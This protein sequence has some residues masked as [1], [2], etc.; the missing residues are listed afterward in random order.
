[1]NSDG[2]VVGMVGRR[3]SSEWNHATSARSSGSSMK[4]FTAYGPLFPIFRGQEHS[5]SIRYKSLC[6]QLTLRWKTMVV[7]YMEYLTHSK[8]CVS[9]NTP[10]AHWW[11]NHLVAIVWKHSWADDLDVKDTYSANDGIGLNISPLKAAA[12]TM[13]STMEG[14]QTSLCR[15]HYL[16]RWDNEKKLNHDVD[17]YEWI[18]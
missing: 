18:Q 4:P 15:Y 6:Y 7:P 3:G 8:L 16:C 12:N 10:V 1:M 9:L 11:W 14:I 2:V 17:S 5:F 13:L